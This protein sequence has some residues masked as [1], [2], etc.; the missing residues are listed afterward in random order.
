MYPD[1]SSLKFQDDNDL[2]MSR[3][4]Q[5]PQ[6]QHAFVNM[7]SSSQVAYNVDPG[8]VPFRS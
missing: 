3:P 1:N 8:C 5:Q 2:Y 7:T 6:P 4:V